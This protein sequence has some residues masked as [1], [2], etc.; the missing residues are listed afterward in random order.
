MKVIAIAAI[1]ADGM[2]ARHAQHH[3]DWTSRADKQMFAAASRKAGVIVLGR[4]TFATFPRPLKDRLHI[5][6]TTHPEAFISTPGVV[7][8]TAA[9]PAEILRNLEARHF[10]EVI[11]GGGA[12]VYRQFIEA[13]LVDELWLTVEPVLFGEGISLLGAGSVDI[14]M[15]LLE[16]IQ[17]SGETMQLKY[18]L[19]D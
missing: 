12:S 16:T 3:T 19:K 13:G 18:A 14:R 15:R 5:V 4:A 1:T 6:M 10:S 7:E 11:I 8:Y 2:I 17:L 9:A